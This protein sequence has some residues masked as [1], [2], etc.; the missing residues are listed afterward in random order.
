MKGITNSGNILPIGY[1]MILGGII[2]FIIFIFTASSI[3]L[4]FSIFDVTLGIIVVIG[5]LI[6]QKLEE[7]IIAF[8]RSS[9]INTSTD[10]DSNL[11]W[12]P[13]QGNW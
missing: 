6:I 1:G 12:R 2:N 7:I 13:G 4:Y 3:M 11:Y 5:G 9:N 10:R 8:S